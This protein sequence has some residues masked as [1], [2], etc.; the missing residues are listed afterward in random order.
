[1]A[2]LPESFLKEFNQSIKNLLIEE[3]QNEEFISFSRP[4][5]N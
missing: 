5:N 3:T 2:T 4:L 1:M